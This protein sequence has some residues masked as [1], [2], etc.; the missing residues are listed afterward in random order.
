MAADAQGGDDEHS[1]WGLERSARKRARGG[2]RAP[3][4]LAGEHLGDLPKTLGIRVVD[5]HGRPLDGVEVRAWRRTRFDDGRVG[6]GGEPVREGRTADGGVLHLGRHGADPFF[7]GNRE[8]PLDPAPGVLLLEFSGRKVT[9]Y[10]FL[11][12]LPCN[13]A[14]ARGAKE[15]HYEEFRLDLPR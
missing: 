7:E 3:A 11:E 8:P 1:A 2:N 10:R 13:L 5:G 9:L 14:F 4:P 6:F 12:V 15:V